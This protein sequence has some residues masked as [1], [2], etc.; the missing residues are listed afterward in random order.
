MKR[1]RF[2][3]EIAKLTLKAAAIVAAY[4]TVKEIHKVHK[5][6]ERIKK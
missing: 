3:I 1:E 5:A 2:C 6:L 4:L